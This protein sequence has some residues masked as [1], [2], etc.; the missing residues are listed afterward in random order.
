MESPRALLSPSIHFGADDRDDKPHGTGGR[1]KAKS[2]DVPVMDEVDFASIEDQGVP[3][4]EASSGGGSH[5]S[6]EEAKRGASEFGARGDG[7]DARET[8]VAQGADQGAVLDEGTR[9]QVEAWRSRQ[10]Q[11]EPPRVVTR[12]SSIVSSRSVGSSAGGSAARRQRNLTQMTDAE[13][14]QHHFR[15]AQQHLEAAQRL[16]MAASQSS[17]PSS[18][19]PPANPVDERD[20]MGDFHPASAS[21]YTDYAESSTGFESSS[22]YSPVSPVS[23]GS[24]ELVND[25]EHLAV[26]PGVS[27]DGRRLEIPRS[28]S[29]SNAA[30]TSSLASS[31]TSHRPLPP[32][33][34]SRH[35]A[36]ASETHLDEKARSSSVS[37]RS[38]P[39]PSYP[40]PRPSRPST[41][42][43]ASPVPAPLLERPRQ[44]YDDSAPL[45]PSLYGDSLPRGV[46]DRIG[47][48]SRESASA[49]SSTT[50]GSPQP[51]QYSSAPTSFS[52]GAL[53]EV[54]ETESCV[55]FDD[56]AS[57]FHDA[58]SSFSHVTTATLPPYDFGGMARGGGGGG[59]MPPSAMPPVP[60]IPSA[61]LQEYEQTTCA[62]EPV[63]APT[64]RSQASYSSSVSASTVAATQGGGMGRLPPARDQDEF[65]GFRPRIAR[66][67]APP[68]SNPNSIHLMSSARWAPPPASYQARTDPPRHVYNQ[69]VSQPVPPSGSTQSDA[70]Y[71]STVSGMQPHSYILS[72]EGRPIPVYASPVAG[73]GLSQPGPAAIP[74]HHVGLAP[75]T[76]RAP[77]AIHSQPLEFDHDPFPPIRQGS[78][79]T[80]F[81]QTSTSLVSNPARWA[82]PQQQ[83]QQQQQ[84]YHP[85]PLSLST[86]IYTQPPPHSSTA[87]SLSLPSPATFSPPSYAAPSLTTLAQPT[88]ARPATSASISS[89]A[90]SSTSD[91]STF[92]LH[93]PSS[94]MTTTTTTDSDRASLLR[95]PHSRLVATSLSLRKMVRSPHVRFKSPEPAIVETGGGTGRGGIRPAD[96][97]GG[98]KGDRSAKAMQQSLGMLM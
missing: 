79:P 40:R 5:A 61:Y 12:R 91:L 46:R 33:S 53:F 65:H 68:T 28:R 37:L 17:I 30:S 88:Y 96:G 7:R 56:A 16:A 44:P 58:Q 20:V 31:P 60:E 6:A 11:A 26:R 86:P 14:A 85:P 73:G 48:I 52:E 22:V 4:Y 83:Q 27:K 82:V 63:R 19:A 81:Q 36:V 92:P 32:P 8:G 54:D 38:S 74:A 89:N 98:D 13:I 95:T 93:G 55:D 90:S 10:G 21:D 29:L 18:S 59:G 71:A 75:T 62:R 1:G 66:P 78:V 77:L 70:S 69:P 15:L 64:L 97:G 49:P 34:T 42:P 67:S 94:T 45:V 50:S 76:S 47:S 23:Y 43:S 35:P 80:S 25:F 41:A 72:P 2:E 39:A 9:E 57:D 3:R 24:P 87:S 51:H 84:Q